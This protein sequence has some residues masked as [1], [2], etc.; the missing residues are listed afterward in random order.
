MS[1]ERNI[2]EVKNLAAGYPGNT[3][4]QNVNLTL[5]AVE[6]LGIIGQNGS[7]KST[8]VKTI[9]GL[10]P[11]KSGQIDYNGQQLNGIAPHE[12]IRKGISYFA[13]GG[14]IMPALSVQ[15]H[16]QLAGSHKAGKLRKTHFDDIFAAFPKLKDMENK[17]AGNLSG[18]ERQML[19]FAILLMQDTRMWLLDEPTAGLSPEMVVFTTD[20]LKKAN[21]DRGITMLLVE[22]N[23]E[24][25]F[26]L[27]TEIAITK[28]GTL[29]TPFRKEDFLKE[30]FLNNFVYN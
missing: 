14:L 20:F 10:L 1:N 22:H 2:L 25:A 13:Q 18:G 26:Q 24:V 6:I 21:Q 30:G 9:Y 5:K 8:L 19:S 29:T 11:N 28:E 16:L 7:G 27:A 3:V 17:R 23:M 15:E 4:L 12:M